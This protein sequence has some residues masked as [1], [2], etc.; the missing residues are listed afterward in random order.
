[1]QN[2]FAKTQ[3]ENIRVWSAPD[4][5]RIVFD[6]SDN[7]K[8]NVFTLNN[9]HRV[10]I[11]FVDTDW[12]LS[13]EPEFDNSNIKKIRHS[14]RN[15]KN[16][17][18]VFDL[19]QSVKPNYFLL[20]PNKTYGYRLVLDLPIKQKKS[21]TASKFQSTSRKFR[22]RDFIVA[23]DPGHGGEDPGAI[24]KKFKTK[25]KDVVLQV[26]KRL[27]KKINHTPGLQAFL[28]R[29]GDYYVGLRQ[30]INK[31]RSHGADLFISIHADSFHDSKASGASVYILSEK[32][33]SSEA[34]RWL[35][36]SE[37][38]ADLIGG[39]SLDDKGD[40]LAQVLLDLSQSAS[41]QASYELAESL[42]EGLSKVTKL[43][44]K[45][46]QQA[47]FAVLKAPDIPSVLVEIGF[48]SNHI[49]EENLRSSQY[50]EKIAQALVNGVLHHFS[51]RRQP[52]MHTMQMAVIHKVKS[53]E[54]LEKIAHQYKTP[55]R[56]IVAHN[57][58]K[59][60][61]IYIGQKIR[62]PQVADTE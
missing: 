41:K 4:N 3:I 22:N 43:H 55:L 19:S 9:P 10:V 34:A 13:K 29:T 30:R 42:L 37:N 21:E 60:D 35:A 33:S 12:K 28:I 48:I 46:V 20:A 38:R 6:I 5:I 58:L 54:T 14:I 31:A 47:G 51:K 26:A 36:E 49:G 39:I 44:Q 25:E 57:R 23:I 56:D 45:Q 50:Q 8:Y 59:S 53:G 27:E 2:S 62:I 17:R 15:Q 40:L 32:G 61:L 1:M 52:S 16:L 7:V 11:D 24:G 18:I